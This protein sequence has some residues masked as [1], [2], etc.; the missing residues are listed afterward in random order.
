VPLADLTVPGRPPLA[1]DVGRYVTVTGHYLGAFDLA[2]RDRGPASGKPSPTAGVW[3][4]SALRTSAGDLVPVVRG[5]AASATEIPPPP[6]GPQTVRGVLQPSESFTSSQDSPTGDPS[7]VD[8]I[9]AAQLVSQY[10]PGRLYD[11]YLVLLPPSPGLEQVEAPAQARG[12]WH[13]LNAGYALQWWVFAGF[14]VLL[15]VRLLRD[16]P[17]ENA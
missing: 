14:A 1:E 9:S 5:W 10:P 13:V 3:A 16:R 11:A 15:W 7:T 4:L 17:E 6:T 12:G 8:M 2:V